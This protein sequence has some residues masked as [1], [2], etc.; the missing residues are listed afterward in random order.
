MMTKWISVKERLPKIGE[1]VLAKSQPSFIR[2]A[3][4]LISNGKKIFFVEPCFEMTDVTHWMPL[5]EDE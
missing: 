1:K 4:F 2:D 3:V 5:S